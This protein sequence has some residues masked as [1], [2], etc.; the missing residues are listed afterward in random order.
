[1]GDGAAFADVLLGVHVVVTSYGQPNLWGACIPVPT[2]LNLQQWEKLC[3]T[4]E[5]HFTFQ[6]LQFGF[7]GG[8]EGPAPTHTFH[9]HPSAVHHST[10][11]AAYILKELGE[12]ATLGPFD[13]PPSLPGL[14][15][16]PVSL[17]ARMALICDMSSWLYPG[18]STQ[19]SV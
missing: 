11:V 18:L 2:N 17:G 12:G 10:D 4:P 3:V 9:N 19:G 13:Q 5:D 7:P 14:K 8:Y 1:M 6:Y 15:L 16:T